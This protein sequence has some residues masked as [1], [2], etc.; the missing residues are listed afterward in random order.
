MGLILYPQETSDIIEIFFAV[1]WGATGI[2]TSGWRPDILLNMYNV[3]DNPTAKNSP[4]PNISVQKLRD[5]GL[6][7]AAIEDGNLS[8][9]CRIRGSSGPF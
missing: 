7:S 2:S 1:I 5:P 9:S 4:S 6:E 8:R 3:Q